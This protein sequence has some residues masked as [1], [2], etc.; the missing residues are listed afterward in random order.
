MNI[1]ACR[2]CGSTE[3][4]H[5]EQVFVA[6]IYEWWRQCLDMEACWARWTEGKPLWYTKQLDDLKGVSDG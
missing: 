6:G 3:G 2:H 4:T 1:N 5:W